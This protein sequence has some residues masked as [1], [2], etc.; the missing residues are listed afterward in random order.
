MV[1]RKISASVGARTSTKIIIAGIVSVTASET[2]TITSRKLGNG[3]EDVGGFAL[4]LQVAE[5]LF[6]LG[7]I[8]FRCAKLSSLKAS[9]VS[10]QQNS[11]VCSLESTDTSL[12]Q[13]NTDYQ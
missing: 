13:T 6:F 12:K 8:L 9:F 1:D 2:H 11:L 4:G 5:M 7:I 3:H 10:P